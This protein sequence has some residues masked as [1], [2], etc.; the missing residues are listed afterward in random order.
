VSTLTRIRVAL[1]P[2]EL[3]SVLAA[4]V[5]PAD[6]PALALR[7]ERLAQ[8]ATREAI[9]STLQNL[10]D[11]AEEPPSAWHHGDPRPPL[12]RGAVLTARPILEVLME[13][14]RSPDRLPIR[15]IALAAQLAWDS[16]SPVYAASE[17]SV[18]EFADDALELL[19]S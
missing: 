14:L 10:L 18:S 9:A 17:A 12:R 16:S 2:N 7:A 1:R 13:R 15:G 19:T 6:D 4:G 5:D 11:A 3:D 8:P